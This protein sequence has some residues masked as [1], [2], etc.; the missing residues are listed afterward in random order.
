VGNVKET[1][2]TADEI[3]KQVFD[4]PAVDSKVVAY[5]LCEIAAQLA[6]LNAHIAASKTDGGTLA[7]V[8]FDGNQ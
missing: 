3:R 2:M 7:V 6:E 1:D 4:P 5:W 8:T